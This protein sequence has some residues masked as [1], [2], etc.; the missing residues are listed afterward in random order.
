MLK[1]KTIGK[2]RREADN[3]DEESL[4]GEDHL[5][6]GLLSRA[7]N[8]PHIRSIFKNLIWKRDV[9]RFSTTCRP[10]PGYTWPGKVTTEHQILLVFWYF[11][12]KGNFALR[13]TWTGLCGTSTSPR[14]PSLTILTDSP[15]QGWPITFSI[16][17]QVCFFFGE[18]QLNFAKGCPF[19]C[20]FVFFGEIQFNFA[21]GC[22]GTTLVWPW[23]GPPPVM[24][25]GFPLDHL[26]MVDY[27]DHID[28]G[29][30][31]WSPRSWL[32]IFI[33][34]IMVD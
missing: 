22:P 8:S 21:K 14:W 25:P 11:C 28:N 5:D 31:S 10:S 13:I 15:H 12:G 16:F 7:K 6:G 4:F 19:L 26:L 32:I 18:I 20:R 30:V 1:T 34:S 24:W 23:R 33:F 17:M 27:L 2:L 9:Q 29:W 3:S